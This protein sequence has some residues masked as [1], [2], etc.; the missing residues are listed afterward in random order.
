MFSTGLYHLNSLE[1]KLL[2]FPFYR[3]THYSYPKFKR[4]FSSPFN[5]ITSFGMKKEACI[6]NKLMSLCLYL[7]NV[8]KNL[9]SCAL[10]PCTSLYL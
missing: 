1:K 7:F 3:M 9:L 5:L 8:H 4:K 10:L 6:Y 2:I